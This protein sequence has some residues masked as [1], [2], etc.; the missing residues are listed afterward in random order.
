VAGLKVSL[1]GS[2]QMKRNITVR[3]KKFSEKQ[4]KAVQSSSRRVASDIETE[5]RANI[6]A[7]GNFSS[8][9]W[10]QGFR[11]LVSFET[12]ADLRIRATHAIK[13]WRVFE[14]GATIFCRPLLWIPLP[15]NNNKVSAKDYGKPLFRVNRLGKNPLLLDDTGPQYVG[16]QSVTIPRKWD[17]RGVVKRASR[18][19]NKYFKEEMKNGR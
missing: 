10:Q 7:G 14:F 16:V 3:S 2:E 12:R 15:W 6:A 9:R 8:S 11:A 18:N 5:G 4:I 17:L 1:D 19:L 13:F